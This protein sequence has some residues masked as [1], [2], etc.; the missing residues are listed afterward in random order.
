M[1]P[2]LKCTCRFLPLPYKTLNAFLLK[3]PDRHVGVFCLSANPAK[4]MPET[5][6]GTTLGKIPLVGVSQTGTCV[7]FCT[8]EK[9][10]TAENEGSAVWPLP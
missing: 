2:S 3:N 8:G 10:Q 5:V 9:R 1:S 4:Q 6:R 7:Y